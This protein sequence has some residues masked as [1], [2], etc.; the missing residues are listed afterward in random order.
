M[1]EE[2]RAI[3]HKFSIGGHEGYLTVGLYD[4]GT[5]G[6]IFLTMNKQ[7]SVMSGIMDSLAI[8]LSLALQYGVPLRDVINKFVHVRFEPSGY[9]SNPHIRIAKSIVDYVARWLGWKFLPADEH[10]ALGINGIHHDEPKP[11]NGSLEAIVQSELAANKVSSESTSPVVAPAAPVET[12]HV[13]SQPSATAPNDL[14]T[15]FQRQT[16]APPCDTCGA[17]MVR[18]GACYKCLNCGSVSG[19]S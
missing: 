4:D 11:E 7:G 14:T 9:T 16:D 15:T 2:R 5:P 6:E 8:S 10:A 17:L 3:T 19:C 18:N 13:A 1:P 12:Q